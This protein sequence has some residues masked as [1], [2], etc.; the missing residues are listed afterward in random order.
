MR[1]ERQR[2]ARKAIAVTNTAGLLGAIFFLIIGAVGI[3]LT[4][5]WTSIWG[6]YTFVGVVGICI[7]LV[8]FAVLVD[9]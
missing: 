7:A 3:E 2:F 5:D 6:G 1:Y 8:T 9:V 4:G